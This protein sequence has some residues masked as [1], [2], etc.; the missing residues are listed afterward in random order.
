MIARALGAWDGFELNMQYFAATTTRF[1]LSCFGPALVRTIEHVVRTAAFAFHP[2]VGEG[3]VRRRGNFW[4]AKLPARDAEHCVN[5]DP[6]LDLAARAILQA[7]AP[8]FI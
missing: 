6:S 8:L 3:L 5:L 2:L 7:C 4:E 1:K